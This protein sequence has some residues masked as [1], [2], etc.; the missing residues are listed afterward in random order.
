MQGML[1]TEVVNA[2]QLVQRG[3][4]KCIAGRMTIHPT[5]QGDD[6][7]DTDDGRAGA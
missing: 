3:G 6:D 4:Q 5:G 1:G 7:D 2:K